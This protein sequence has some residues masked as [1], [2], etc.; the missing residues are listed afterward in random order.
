MVNFGE[1]A[2]VPAKFD[3]RTFYIHNP[4]VTLMRT[5]AAECAEL[6]R[7]LADKANAYRGP[8]TVLLPLKAISIISAAGK[9]FDDAAADTALFDAIRQHLRPGIPL[10]EMDSEINAP[11]FAA[12]CAK[13]L[14]DS[15]SAG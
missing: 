10:I 5:N 13:A 1:K 3:D 2:T 14:L 6:G 7:I 4:Q 15:L 9:P 11:E 8:V 12:A